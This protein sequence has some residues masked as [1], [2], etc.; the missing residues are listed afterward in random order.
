MRKNPSAIL[1]FVVFLAFAGLACSL[2]SGLP[3]VNI[4]STSTPA[5]P[6][7]PV[8]DMLSFVLPAYTYNLQPGEIV[9]GTQ[10]EYVGRNGNA[11]D[12]RID[13][14]ATQKRSGDSFIWN[15]PVAPGI[16]GNFNL[17]LTT[18]IF[19]GLPVAGKV[20]MIVLN[21]FA[22]ELSVPTNRPIKLA[23]TNILIDYR[24][25]VGRAVPG[26]TL[27]YQGIVTQGQGGQSSQLAALSGLQGY[28]Y[29][30]KGDSLFWF[31][32]LREN[33]VVR[34]NLRTISYSETEL[35]LTGT[36]ELQILE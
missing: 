36:A 24:V 7:T 23:Y 10:L 33:V 27:V 1:V 13:G 8:G 14:L 4:F 28:P 18:N 21:P 19:G 16:Y 5:A 22:V 26:T 11:Y 32:S 17:R 12:V 29:L 3:S 34:Y 35:H 31:G 30:A 6:P 9:P 2:P 15:G 20:E 25:P